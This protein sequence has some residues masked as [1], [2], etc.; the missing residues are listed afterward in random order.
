M[1]AFLIDTS[2]SFPLSEMGRIKSL[3]RVGDR[4]IMFDMVAHDCG[5]MDCQAAIT[6]LQFVGGGGTSLS[7]AMLSVGQ[8]CPNAPVTIITDGF[9]FD[10]AEAR[11]IADF[12]MLKVAEIIPF[13][14]SSHNDISRLKEA[15]L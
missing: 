11:E 8:S 3:L 14:T 12:Y 5:V 15:F 7:A 9:I 1:R 4:V 6:M 10:I 2:G 13:E